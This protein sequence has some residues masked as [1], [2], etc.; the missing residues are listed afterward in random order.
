[1]NA[2]KRNIR[3]MIAL[4][5][6]V[7]M[8]AGCVEE[9][10]EETIKVKEGDEIIFG[11]RAGYENN[12]PSTKTIYKGTT[13]QV[14]DKTLEAVHWMP[15]DK[16]MIYCDQGN[17]TAH[18]Q[19]TATGIGSDTEAITSL[20]K[21]QLHG[22]GNNGVQWKNIKENDH[23]FYAVYPSPYQFSTPNVE[24]GLLEASN[25][26][27]RIT[28]DGTKLNCYLPVSQAPSSIEVKADGSG[29]IAHP[30]MNYAYMI[31]KQVVKAN[32]NGEVPAGVDL[33]FRPIV[34]ALEVTMTFPE[35]YSYEDGSGNDIDVTYSD[36]TISNVRLETTDD[37]PIVGPFSLDLADY[38]YR[39]TE[40]T[41]PDVTI[42]QSAEALNTVG[43]QLYRDVNGVPTPLTIG[44]NQTLTFTVFMLPTEIDN[45]K[46]YVDLKS[47][48]LGN[49]KIEAHKKQFLVNL[50]LP[51][52][53]SETQT[54]TTTGSNWI[55]Q[56]PEDVLIEGLS[57]PGTANSFS[58]NYGRTATSLD[59]DAT[60][61]NNNY[62][63]QTLSFDNQWNLGV[64]C[65]EIVCDRVNSTSTT[66][67]L[68]SQNVMCN[69]AS[70]GLN[71]T[72]AFN[73]VLA[74]LTAEG[75]EKEFAMIII[76]Y[77]PVGGSGNPDRNPSL[78]MT[79][80][81]NFYSNYTYSG[82]SLASY[83]CLYKPGLDLETIRKTPLMIVARPS[84]EGEDSATNVDAGA[85]EG[86]NILT[87]K[88]W[89]TL[90][91]KWYKR[92]YDAMLFKG[93]NTDGLT[94]S[95]NYGDTYDN[96]HPTLDAMEDYIYGANGEYNG[97]Y[98]GR[99]TRVNGNQRFQY[100]SDQNYLVWAQEWRRVSATKQTLTFTT[101]TY[102][103]SHHT[104]WDESYSLKQEDIIDCLVRSISNENDRVYFN[105][106]DGF[107]VTNARESCDFYWRGNMGDIGGYADDI[108][109]W[110]YP[111]LLKY[112]AADVTGPLGVIIMDRVAHTGAGSLLPEVIYM[113]NWR[114]TLETSQ[115]YPAGSAEVEDWTDESLN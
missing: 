3:Y 5:G 59:S 61:I 109:A 38:E 63:T 23:T 12:D 57:I 78:F 24:S 90:V 6:A 105:S 41:Y 69:G 66:A 98:D 48:S 17:Q 87:V 53:S 72:D 99:P 26:Q 73:R 102:P 58:Y 56:L 104:L 77:Q 13:Y 75:N 81:K 2:M 7:T 52:T 21:M 44:S 51:A 25:Y 115:K 108:N 36:L 65:F 18:Y 68:A 71:V 113:N 70:V 79:Q 31:A 64:R 106:L 101:W 34:T 92:G 103:F 114:H 85:G 74:K 28:G 93:K 89:G 60:S 11:A 39:D 91:D 22:V 54:S 50:V 67:T 111:E 35:D 10:L 55:T 33:D 82:K 100:S 46:I 8:F 49:L 76:T 83:T 96:L 15:G 30:N 95:A 14:G 62:M 42:P 84:Q 20:K 112:S 94:S 9:N 1:M 27:E 107:Y 80:L 86:Y 16:V 110:F 32:A 29:Y 4:A 47:G 97:T 37:S 19:V 40:V 45:L 43:V 88:G